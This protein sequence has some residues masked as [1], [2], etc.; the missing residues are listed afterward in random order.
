[1]NDLYTDIFL[2]FIAINISFCM[3]FFISFL[4]KK[5]E[6]EETEQEKTDSVNI[7]DKDFY[8]LKTNLITE[9]KNV[10]IDFKKE[11]NGKM[12]HSF[13]VNIP[14]E[15]HISKRPMIDQNGD[16]IFKDR[17]ILIFEFNKKY[18]ILEDLFNNIDYFRADI[19]YLENTYENFRINLIERINYNEIL[20]EF[21]RD[22]KNNKG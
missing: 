10:Y 15:F 5:Q 4:I 12:K 11:C 16:C 2:F 6:P 1:M 20:F 22:N 9:D 7:Q 13:I 8:N 14:K 21:F 18:K 17:I 19:Y 3:I